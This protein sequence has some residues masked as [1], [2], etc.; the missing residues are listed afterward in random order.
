MQPFFVCSILARLA[1]HT[2]GSCRQY[3]WTLPTKPNEI[4]CK[5]GYGE[6]TFTLTNNAGSETATTRAFSAPKSGKTVQP[7]SIQKQFRIKK[8]NSAFPI[9]K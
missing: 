3:L 7:F 8:M 2:H 9:F 6:E 4:A 1:N 5:I